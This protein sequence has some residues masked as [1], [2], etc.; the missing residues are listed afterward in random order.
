MSLPVY[1]DRF[2]VFIKLGHYAIRSHDKIQFKALKCAF[3]KSSRLICDLTIS[4]C[5][6]LDK[7]ACPLEGTNLPKISK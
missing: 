5:L 1:V 3:L 4:Q 6:I 2:V 7:N